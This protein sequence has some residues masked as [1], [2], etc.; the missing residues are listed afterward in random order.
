[1]FRSHGASL[2]RL[3]SREALTWFSR[4]PPVPIAE[5]ASFGFLQVILLPF[6]IHS[7]FIPA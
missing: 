6:Q 1:M 5:I 3:D 7:P 2:L 4:K